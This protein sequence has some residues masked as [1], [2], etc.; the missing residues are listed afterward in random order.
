LKTNKLLQETYK[1]IFSK[2]CIYYKSNFVEA[3]ISWESFNKVLE[4]KDDFYFCFSE[5]QILFVPKKFF[6][7]N[8]DI[9]FTMELLK[10]KFKKENFSYKFLV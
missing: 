6:N 5:I 1:V 8:H 7:N 9:F 3:K 2:D 10:S 4:T